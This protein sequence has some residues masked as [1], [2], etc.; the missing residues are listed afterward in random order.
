[1]TVDPVQTDPELYRVVLENSRVRVVEYQDQPGAS[2]KEHS[3][4]D[5][6]M[7]PLS[8]FRRRIRSG[9]REVVVDLEAGQV[10]WL[11][12]QTHAGTNIGN[13]PSHALFIELKESDPDAA[14]RPPGGDTLPGP[15][16]VD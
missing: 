15:R 8:G 3:H 1:M 9:D 12:A 6:V 2:T 7:V 16:P 11:D 4:P 10:R 13:T 14:D 5:T